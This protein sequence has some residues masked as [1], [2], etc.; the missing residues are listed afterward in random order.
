M[1]S[2]SVWWKASG[3]TRLFWRVRFGW[4]SAYDS[5]ADMLHAV[6]SRMGCSIEHVLS[7]EV[8]PEELVH[9]LSALLSRGRY[10]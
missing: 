10:V 8:E 3:A 7:L 4:F 6:L 5:Q 1:K 2:F 9:R